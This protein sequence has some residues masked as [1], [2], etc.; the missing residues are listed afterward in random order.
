M[1]K[2]MF[3]VRRHIVQVTYTRGVDRYGMTKPNH[4]SYFIP[5]DNTIN[6]GFAYQLAWYAGGFYYT[7]KEEVS[8]ERTEKMVEIR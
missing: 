5:H 7:G 6:K 4:W 8:L 1:I 2:N 3:V